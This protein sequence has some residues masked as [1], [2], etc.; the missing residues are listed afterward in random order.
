[1]TRA[2]PLLLIVAVA[3]IAALAGC[4]PTATPVGLPT[5]SPASATPTESPSE[6]PV[7]TPTPTTPPTGQQVLFTITATATATGG[8]HAQVL[9]T[10]VVYAPTDTATASDYA[11]LKSQ[12]F[13]FATVYPTA[14]YI[15]TAITSKL[16]AG[17]PAWPSS[18][19]SIGMS[20]GDYSA[21]SGDY[22]GFESG[23]A[24][25]ILKKLPGVV[26]GVLPVPT[27]DSASGNKGW[28]RSSYGFAV[29]WDGETSEIPVAQRVALSNCHITLSATAAANSYAAAWPAHP[30][31][32][33]GVGCEYGTQT[34]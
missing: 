29:A 14:H 3:A 8:S 2:R 24:S 16:A 19:V 27:V 22:G 21:W 31:T 26:H 18:V 6:T 4:T 34:F 7:A 1:M 9:L 15:T 28:A 33:G 11:L 13:D 12:C 25:G 17:S 5:S 30:Q 10:E 32:F 20:V 23:C